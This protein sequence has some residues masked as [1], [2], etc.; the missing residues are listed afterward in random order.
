MINILLTSNIKNTKKLFEDEW[1]VL[2]IHDFIALDVGGILT[3]Y[4]NNI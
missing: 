4:K 2:P 1:S 3:E